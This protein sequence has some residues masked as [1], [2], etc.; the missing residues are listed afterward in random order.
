L[1]LKISI[2]IP[3]FNEAK[4][5]S[6]TLS[7][8]NASREAFH[9]LGWASECIVCDNN[10]TDQT[11][12]IARAA[13]ATVVFE[14]INQIAR[15]RNTG[16]AAATGDWLIFVDA[17]SLASVELFAEVAEVIKSGRAIAGGATVDLEGDY[18]L[19]KRMIGVWNCVSRSLKWVAG[20]FIFCE[21][22]AFRK[23]GGFSSEL[24]VTEEIDLSKRLKKLAK[25]EQKKIVILHKHPLKTSARKMH[26]YS[27]REHGAFM[28]R[29]VF[30]GGGVFHNRAACHPWYD[31]RR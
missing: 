9:T 23:I 16:A 19:A 12:E 7:Q 14:P 27:A 11:G 6:A 26:L 2:V 1:R 20:S 18:K 5:I 21:T 30:S 8:I 31:G 13:G 22:R 28:L 4:L 3:A 24:F 17:D 15:A 10:S 29:C 25:E